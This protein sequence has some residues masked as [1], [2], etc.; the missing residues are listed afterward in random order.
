MTTVTARS[1]S[2]DP[3]IIEKKTHRPHPVGEEKKVLVALGGNAILKHR[4]TG[5]AE[6]QLHNIREICKILAGLVFAGYHIAITHGNGPQVGDILMKNE[7]AKESL[8]PM[9]LDI[10]GAESQGMI[11]YML[12][13]SLHNE[14][15]VAGVERRVAT[16]L[17]QTLVDAEDPAFRNPEKPVGPF[18]TAMEASQLRAAKGW[19]MV[20]DAGRGYRRV[21]PSP[22]PVKII[23][24][25]M[26]RSLFDE[27]YLV[28]AAGGGGV[29]V[30]KDADNTL[31]GVEAV[32][33]KDHTAAVLAC[34]L[35]VDILFILTDV[36]QVCLNF[37]KP[38]QK[39][40]SKIS[41]SD[42]EQFLRQGQFSKGS[43]GPKIES[44]LRFLE[45][46]GKEV[47]ITSPDSVFEALA[48]NAGT[49]ICKTLMCT[50]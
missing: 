9:P 21:L 7:L 48:G 2:R 32:I 33:D 23:E 36:Q 28:I 16:F 31:R 5:T 40:L 47:I 41:S 25:E 1:A 8:P 49:I 10:C 34:V 12:Q 15:C 6:E 4:E 43:M 14:L 42:A 30:T 13:Q 35:A 26:I 37:G 11:G 18:Y 38:D 27:G 19:I 39:P 17:T 45:A 3:V 24:G 50:T 22:E 46:G 29:P 20:N 44:A